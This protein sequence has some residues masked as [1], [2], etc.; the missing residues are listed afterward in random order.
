MT[1]AIG[2]NPPPQPRWPAAPPCPRGGQDAVTVEERS[3]KV[4]GTNQRPA[5]FNQDEGRQNPILHGGSNQGGFDKDGK[6]KT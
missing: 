5:D 6:S 1:S 2:L 3:T 4:W